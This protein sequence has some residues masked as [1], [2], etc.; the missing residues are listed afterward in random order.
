MISEMLKKIFGDV[1]NENPSMSEADF[2]NLRSVVQKQMENEHPPR[3]AFIGESG[4]GKSTTLNVLFNAGVAVSHFEPCTQEEL[5]LDVEVARGKIRIYDMPGLGES[6]KKRDKHLATYRRILEGVDVALWILD[7]QYRAFESVERYLTEELK[8]INPKIANKMV[9]AL[10][11]VDLVHPSDWHPIANLP[12]EDQKK[13]IEARISDITKRV[14][15]AIPRWDGYVIGY[16][17]AKYYNLPHLFLAMLE[18]MPKERRWILTDRKAIA[19]FL[20]KVD[21]RVRPANAQ[22]Q[23]KSPEELV[24]EL[25]ESMT[26]E[27]RETLLKN[28][29]GVRSLFSRLINRHK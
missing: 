19:D 9:F 14:R 12:S 21:E 23:H 1:R 3:V 25:I 13:N 17:A 6:I 28:N 29:E 27:Q 8:L 11:K 15:E 2:E 26:D 20:E 4:V 18:A 24:A 16:S 22:S 5:A 10:N 7:A